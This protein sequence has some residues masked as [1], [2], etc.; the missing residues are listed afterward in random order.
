MTQLSLRPRTCRALIALLSAVV[1]APS[2]KPKAAS[3]IYWGGN[4]LS[5]EDPL[6]GLDCDPLVPGEC[7][8]PFPSN[9]YLVADSKTDTGWHVQFRGRTLPIA[10]GQ[11]PVD[12]TPWT[13][14]DGFSPGSGAFA[15]FP[16]VD[17]AGM[18]KAG[19]LASPENIAL[20][21]TPSSPTVIIEADTGARVPHWTELDM[22]PTDNSALSTRSLIIRPAIRLKDNTRY[23]IAIRNLVDGSGAT[24]AA[25]PTFAALRDGTAPQM[26][27][28]NPNGALP[29]TLLDPTVEPRRGLYADIFSHLSKAGVDKGS[30]QL[31]WDFTTASQKSTVSDMLTVRDDALTKV[32]TAGP[33]YT[34]VSTQSCPENCPDP[35]PSAGAP[36][37]PIYMRIVGYMTVPSYLTTAPTAAATPVKGFPGPVSIPGMVFEDINTRL[38]RDPTTRAPVQNGTENWPFIVSVPTDLY[39]AVSAGQSPGGPVVQQGHGL[40]GN[41]AEGEGYDGEFDRLAQAYGYVTIAVPFQGFYNWDPP[42]AEQALEGNILH[43]L[44]LVESQV[45]GQV[46]QLLAMRMMIGQ[47]AKD[48]LMNPNGHP[49]ID[50]T[51]RYYRGDSQG[52]IMGAGYMAI[53][54]DVT[55]GVLGEPGMPYNVL[56][57]RS[58]D[59]AG[60]YYLLLLGS[61][62]QAGGRDINLLLG[63]VQMLWDR[64]EPDGFAPY[65]TT[66]TLPKTPSH[67]VLLNVAIGD[68]QVTPYGAH[69]LARTMGGVQNLEPV[70]REIYGI[71]DAAGP[72]S[73]NGMTEFNFH[74]DQNPAVKL[75][76]TN[77]PNQGPDDC[78]PHDKVRQMFPVFEQT[79]NFFATGMVQNYCWGDNMLPPS[80]GESCSTSNASACSSEPPDMNNQ[81]RGGEICDSTSMTCQEPIWSCD[82]D[83]RTGHMMAP[84]TPAACGPG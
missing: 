12:P 65:I 4:G 78:D 42:I 37:S 24:L 49:L 61:Y 71:P 36:P 79:A 21:M 68:Q 74:L 62:A 16:N 84:T 83:Y 20:S 13:Y 66:N 52:G 53:S 29:K 58:S 67:N 70:N 57:P 6:G 46:N 50:T 54:T 34:I 82:F 51:K 32:G 40:F 43:F 14:S 81:G 27:T 18:W 1:A 45:Q 23:I 17:V 76:E 80:T 31:A 7:G 19:T 44:G 63:G 30:L 28:V 9:V 11:G 22:S 39:N 33:S 2:C 41:P 55:R 69:I 25:T 56:L 60:S 47:F 3:G 10:A 38:N 8:Y 59:Y 15:Y 26:V 35:P 73:G 77:I 48:P 5:S 75:N 72:F 64:S